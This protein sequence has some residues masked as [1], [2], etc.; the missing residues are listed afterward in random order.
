[1]RA[2]HHASGPTYTSNA[3]HAMMI[4]K[5]IGRL[6]VLATA[7]AFA[8]IFAAAPVSAAPGDKPADP[9]ETKEQNQDHVVGEEMC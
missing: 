7:A 6:A 2:L 5:T 9:P 3:K 8:I 4:R 1:M